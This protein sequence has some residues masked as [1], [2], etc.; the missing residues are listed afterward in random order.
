MQNLCKQQRLAQLP[1]LA[2]KLRAFGSKLRSDDH[3]EELKSVIRKPWMVK[4]KAEDDRSH[5]S[6]VSDHR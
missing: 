6:V 4:V 5:I 1:R 2:A 3:V